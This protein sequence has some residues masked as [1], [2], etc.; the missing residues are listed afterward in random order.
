MYK[1]YMNDLSLPPKYNYIYRNPIHPVVPL[2]T[3]KNAIFIIGAYPSAKFATIDSETDVPVGDNLG[4][5]SSER[6]FDGSRVR[7]VASGQELEENYLNPLGLKRENC[8]ITDL[9][10][11]FLFKNGH[12]KKY[13][14]LGCSWPERETRTS[15][16]LYA[17]QGINWL[18]EELKL[19][20][21][22]LVITLGS[23]VAGILQGVHGQKQR[24][25]LLGGDVKEITIGNINYPVIHMAHPGIVMR[26]SSEQNPWPNLHRED[27]IP[28]ATKNIEK[29]FS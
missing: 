5:F 16:E 10:R 22:R 18:Q 21:P 12:I 8:W 29:L 11:I 20:N 28:T 6:Y 25:L 14:R 2:E 24:N 17:Q 9:V 4:P 26:P 19:A 13:R 23:E 1:N 15:F 7:S 3:T 27:H